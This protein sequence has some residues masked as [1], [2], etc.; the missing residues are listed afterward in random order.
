[1]NKYLIALLV[2]SSITGPAPTALAAGKADIKV[3]TQNQYLG[4]DLG[5]IIGAQT[6]GAYAQAVV[7][8]L[9]SIAANNFRERAGAL[10]ESIHDRQ[11]H[12]VAMQEVFA[13]EC[14]D[15]GYRGLR[16]LRAGLQ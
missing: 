5:P 6:P 11:P 14:I 4:A 7:D 8:A 16:L 3:M 12:L 15:V 9:Q 13:F 1:M 10:A 2:L